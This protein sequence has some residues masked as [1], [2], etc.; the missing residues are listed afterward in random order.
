[1]LNFSGFQISAEQFR[2]EVDKI[3]GDKYVTVGIHEDAGIHPDSGMTNATLGAIQHFGADIIRQTKNGTFQIK[4]PA[5]PWLDI[6]VESGIQEYIRTI[7]DGLKSGLPF[8]TIMKQIGL[9]AAAAVQEYM[10][11]LKEPPNAKSTIAQ[12]GSDNPL[13]DT[14]E[15]RQSVTSLVSEGA[16]IP[17]GIE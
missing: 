7:S 2:K 5:R 9:E 12:K 3:R 4:I 14:G 16:I 13:I 1:M 17:E 10:T 11:N 6:G 15:L 8:D